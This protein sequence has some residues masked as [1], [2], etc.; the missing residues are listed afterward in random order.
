MRDAAPH[1][2]TNG[3]TNAETNAGPGRDGSPPSRNPRRRAPSWVRTL[4]PALMVA[5]GAAALAAAA[6]YRW[7]EP[8]EWSLLC[9]PAPWQPGCVGRSL[10]IQSF[11]DQRL[12]WVALGL[13]L[14][15]GL[16]R[17]RWLAAVALA[18]GTAGLVL[19]CA[20]LGAPAALSALL[21]FSRLTKPVG[22]R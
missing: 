15:A 6:R 20:G 1:G 8:Q 9:D 19:Y 18:A 12:A 7:V 17:L 21:V 5:A 10:V 11:I 14:A 13:A 4:G 2:E 3:E 22:P 16:L